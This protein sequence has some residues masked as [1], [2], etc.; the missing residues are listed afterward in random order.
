MT[1]N[2]VI[3]LSQWISQSIGKVS[4]SCLITTTTCTQILSL[5]TTPLH[6][7]QTHTLQ[8][9][10]YYHTLNVTFSYECITTFFPNITHT[11]PSSWVFLKYPHYWWIQLFTD[12][13][14]FCSLKQRFPNYGSCKCVVTVQ[15]LKGDL[16]LFWFQQITTLPVHQLLKER[17]I[18]NFGALT[19]YLVTE[20]YWNNIH[21]E[22]KCISDT[23][24]AHSTHGR[25]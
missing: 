22:I 23:S 3:K 25:E 11:K 7:T 13:R 14:S 15:K 18:H 9:E 2:S 5:N 6:H 10:D 1:N 24:I 17:W 19:A 8:Y 21:D 4:Q 12:C 20:F 16:K